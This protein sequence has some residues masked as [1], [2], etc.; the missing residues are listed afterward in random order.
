MLNARRSLIRSK[1]IMAALMLFTSNGWALT[2]IEKSFAEL[3]QQADLVVIGTVEYIDAQWEGVQTASRIV[4]AVT[5]GDLQV[6]KGAVT[7]STYVLRIAGG[8][9]GEVRQVY[10]G[11]PQLALGGRYALFVRGNG[12]DLF[13]L[14][15]VD[16]GV[17]EVNW[18]APTRQYTARSLRYTAEHKAVN[19]AASLPLAELIDRIQAHLPAPPTP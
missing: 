2:V 10:P 11:L 3:V 8:S 9:V 12:Q 19:R 14:V 13:P 16:Q 17:Y 6:I 4:S 7:S 1:C 5:L 18:D 15:G